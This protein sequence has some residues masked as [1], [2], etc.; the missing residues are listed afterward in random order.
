MRHPPAADP[1]RSA[2]CVHR[3]YTRAHR[4]RQQLRRRARRSQPAL[5]AAAASRSRGFPTGWYPPLGLRATRAMGPPSSTLTGARRRSP[6]KGSPVNSHRLPRTV[7]PSRYDIRLEPDL[8]AATY[9]GEESIQIEV[10]DEVDEV[11]LNAVELTFTRVEAEGP[12]GTRL[13]GTSSLDP[14]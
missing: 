5:V 7:V 12:D 1:G 9:A 14:A 8:D 10:R 13:E 6:G 3:S 2:M 11:Q 4:P